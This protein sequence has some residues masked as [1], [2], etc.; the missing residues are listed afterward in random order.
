MTRSPACTRWAKALP[1]LLGVVVAALIGC[2]EEP[3]RLLEQ[4]DPLASGDAWLEVY[5][6]IA[7]HPNLPRA[8]EVFDEMRRTVG[9]RASLRVLEMG[10]SP[11]ALALP[12][13]TILLSRS[14]L[15]LCY[16]GVSPEAGDARLAF[17][18][19]HELTHVANDDFWHA[20][21]FA[22]VRG[23]EGRDEAS[24]RLQELLAQDG[25]D[26]QVLELRADDAGLLALIQA[27]YDPAPLLGGDRSFFDEWTGGP[28]GALAYADPSHPTP[29]DRARFVQRRLSEVAGKTPLFEQGLAAFEEAEKLAAEDGGRI[30]LQAMEAKYEEAVERFDRFR[31]LFPGREVLSNLSLAHLRLATLRLA[32][33][34][35][36]LVNRYYLPTVLD[37]VTLAERAVNRGSGE[38]SSA[39]FENEAYQRHMRKATS[40]LEEAVDR[41]PHYLPARLNLVAAYVLDEKTA[42]AALLARRT[43]ERFPG[44]AEAAAAWSGAHLAYLATGSSFLDA[45]QI[46]QQVEAYRR[47]FP[48]EPGIAF[49]LA[50]FQSYDGRLDEARPVWRAFLELQ[51]EGPWADVARDWVGEERVELA[52]ASSGR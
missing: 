31:R 48:H 4:G 41:D 50:A 2:N 49:N 30:A 16:D 33:C 8:R 12:D 7:D 34:D 39:C 44:E 51:P 15:D 36:T 24:G 52:A 43:M 38:Y 21:A 25:R 37:P 14:G 42:S 46:L 28:D 3:S 32:R 11:R 29:V 18:F 20:S 35:G 27:G 17:L 5:P 26:R 40:L 23:V 1:T 19:G 47:A 22:S 13:E 10:R 45:G 9:V 6:E